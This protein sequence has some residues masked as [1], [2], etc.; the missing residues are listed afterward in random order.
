MVRLV[1]VGFRCY[2]QDRN[3]LLK[4]GFS[5]LIQ[6]AIPEGIQ[7]VLASPTKFFLK[8]VDLQ[9]VK[10]FAASIRAKRKPEPYNGKG[11]F[12]G[13]ETIVRKEGK[14]K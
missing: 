3:L 5:H 14:K 2:V 4:L 12:V 9:Q 11:I 1:G 10:L 7:V 6:M 13:D 8:G